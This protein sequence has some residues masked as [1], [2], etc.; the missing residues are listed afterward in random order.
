MEK[1]LIASY[2][3]QAAFESFTGYFFVR[4]AVNCENKTG[5]FRWEIVDE[6]FEKTTC[7]S[8]LETEIITKVKNLSFWNHPIYRGESRDGYTFLIVK[9]ENG[10]IIPS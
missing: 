7:S 3:K 1:E 5:R 6:N 9:I 4:F 10:N 8:S 2:E